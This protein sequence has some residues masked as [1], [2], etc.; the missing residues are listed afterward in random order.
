MRE[1]TGELNMTVVVVVAVAGLMAFFSMVAWPIVKG[2]IERDANCSDAV[3]VPSDT[4]SGK[5]AENICC[6]M[7]GESE[8]FTCP[9][10]G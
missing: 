9:Y 1:A 7:P 4:C 5:T 3:C 6:H 2:G 8:R 10:K